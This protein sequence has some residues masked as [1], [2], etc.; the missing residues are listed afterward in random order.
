MNRRIKKTDN[1]WVSLSDIMTG[2]MVIFMFVS[3][4]YMVEINKVKIELKTSLYNELK[5]DFSEDL[6]SW[7]MT[8][9]KD[10]SI[11]FLNP[12]ILF[13]SGSHR[14]REKFKRILDDFLPRYF[15]LLN[16]D[17]YLN[18]IAEIRIEGHTDDVPAPYLDKDPYIANIKL[19]QQRASEVLKYF[20]NMPFYKA[21]PEKTKLKLRFLITVNGLSYGRTLDDDGKL[22]AVTGKPTNNELSRRVEIR[23]VPIS[24]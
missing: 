21:L 4:S 8:L 18:K 20:H 15:A 7:D 10:L 13:V 24:Q 19:S 16:Q 3:V 6:Q 5:R 2:L 1:N 17:K 14:L 22:T 23:I 12:D 11:K 9:D